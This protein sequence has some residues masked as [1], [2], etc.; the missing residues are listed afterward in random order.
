VRPDLGF[1]QALDNLVM[2]CLEKER[3]LRPA[4]AREVIREIERA[5]EEIRRLPVPLQPTPGIAPSPPVS[6]P[7]SVPRPSTKP[8][9]KAGVMDRWAHGKRFWVGLAVMTLLPI[10]IGPALESTRFSGHDGMLGLI[11]GV[12]GGLGWFLV[13]RGN[14]GARAF[15]MFLLLNFVLFV[16]RRSV[17]IYK[18]YS[19]MRV[20]DVPATKNVYPIGELM[21]AHRCPVEVTGSRWAKEQGGHAIYLIALRNISSNATVTD[22]KADTLTFDD[23]RNL[24]HDS[25]PQDL[26]PTALRPGQ[27]TSIQLTGP[28][29]EAAH[30]AKLV[31]KQVDYAITTPAGAKQAGTW[32]NP[33]FQEDFEKAKQR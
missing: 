32:T 21:Q 14:W 29:I 2:R 3:D 20:T 15:A 13:I 26:T 33:H 27:T 19:W 28:Y 22:W 10:L 4:N 6:P 25:P 30:D 11:T 1:P 16:G 17:E 7:A 18:D 5:E 24:I 12:M 9:R 8:A 23:D 31:F